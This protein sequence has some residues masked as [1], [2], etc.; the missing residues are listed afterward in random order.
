MIGDLKRLGGPEVH[1]FHAAF[2][3]VLCNYHL[4][5]KS[6]KLCIFEM[7]KHIELSSRLIFP[8]SFTR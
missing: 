1:S 7:L 2:T 4:V 3:I 5:V 6:G 8:A